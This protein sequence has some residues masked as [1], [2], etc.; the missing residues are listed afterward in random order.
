MLA[1]GQHVVPIEIKSGKTGTL[2]S[3][4]YFLRE[5][6]RSFA[7]RLNGDVPSLLE[8]STRL[9]DGTRLDYTLLSLPLYA[10]GQTKR[11]LA[12]HLESAKSP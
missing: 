6:R 3:L 12:A 5:K 9:A 8:D 10:I 4:H 11:L 1:E 7:V 2:R